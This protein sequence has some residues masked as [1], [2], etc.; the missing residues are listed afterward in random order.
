MTDLAR[1]VGSLPAASLVTVAGAARDFHPL[2]LTARS[3]DCANLQWGALRV[4][5]EVRCSRR[6]EF[7]QGRL[8]HGQ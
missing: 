6:G 2:P 8:T 7:R 4:K 5:Q 1:P 3:K